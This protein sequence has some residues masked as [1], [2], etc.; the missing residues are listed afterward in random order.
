MMHLFNKK[1]TGLNQFKNRIKLGGL[2]SPY[3][4]GIL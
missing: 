4:G 3:K 2:K 1:P